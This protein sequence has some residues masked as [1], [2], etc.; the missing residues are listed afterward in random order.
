MR[1]FVFGAA[2]VF[3]VLM[4]AMT[5]VVV[6]NGTLSPVVLVALAVLALLGFGIIGAM[7]DGRNK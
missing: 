1:A 6:A 2:V 4:T 7:L 5:V 3:L